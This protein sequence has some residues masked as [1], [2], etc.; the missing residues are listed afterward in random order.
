MFQCHFLRS[1]EEDQVSAEEVLLSY[2]RLLSILLYCLAYHPL[3][4]IH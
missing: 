2:P 4:H 1:Y 3:I